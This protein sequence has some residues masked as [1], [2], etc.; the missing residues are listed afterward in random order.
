MLERNMGEISS[1][2]GEAK[3]YLPFYAHWDFF[4]VISD[5]LLYAPFCDAVTVSMVMLSL[6]RYALNVCIL[7]VLVYTKNV[8]I[9]VKPYDCFFLL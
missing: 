8:E 1:H 6:S 5:L 3:Y 7:S 4:L 2:H 9:P